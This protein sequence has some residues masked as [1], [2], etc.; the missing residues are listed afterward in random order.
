M[1][2][3]LAPIAQALIVQ[4]SSLGRFWKGALVAVLAVMIGYQSWVARSILIAE[5]FSA[6]PPFWKAI[7][8][9]IPSDGVVIGLTQDYGY[10]LM[11]WG[12]HKV[13][14]WPYSTDLS[15]AR[16]NQG[17]SASDFSSFT[18]GKDYFLV[19]AFN[20]LDR[21]P[22]L[23]KILDGYAIAVQGNGYILYDLRRSK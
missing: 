2:L 14:L 23:K 16:G 17:V 7:G 9:A 22:D 11:Y 4:A 6:D 20:Q 13:D 12:W 21:Q 15:S 3:G 19:T 5:N 10:D 18:A 8:R 1:A